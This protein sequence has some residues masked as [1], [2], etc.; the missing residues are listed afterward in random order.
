MGE[1]NVRKEI[2][3]NQ[4]CYG[5][6]KRAMNHSYKIAYI[7]HNITSALNRSFFVYGCWLSL[8]KSGQ[9]RQKGGKYGIIWVSQEGFQEAFILV[10]NTEC[11]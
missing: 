11:R 1:R 8:A 4:E 9:K 6:Y 5:L 7:S 2:I 10:T 3:R